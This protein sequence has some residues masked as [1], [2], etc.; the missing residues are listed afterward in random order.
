MES[1]CLKC[2]KNTENIDPEISS[3]S[4][5]RAMILSKCAICGSKNSRFNKNQDAKGLLTKLGIKNTI[6]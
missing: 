1:Y 4:N 6:K 5:G 3:T 2:R